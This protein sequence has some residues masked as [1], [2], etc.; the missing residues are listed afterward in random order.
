MRP[1]IYIGANLKNGD[2]ELFYFQDFESYSNGLR[3]STKSGHDPN[4]EVRGP[5]DLNHIFHY[6][7]AL[8]LLMKC[9]LRRRNLSK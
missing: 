1:L 9:S 5:S 3:Y 7:H 2:R 8:E 6:E 4:F